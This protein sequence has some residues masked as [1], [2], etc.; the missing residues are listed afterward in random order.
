MTVNSKHSALG[1]ALVVGMIL[2]MAAPRA[3]A[4][5]SDVTLRGTWAF[6]TTGTIILPNVGPAPV[7]AV[8]RINFDG[9]GSVAGNQTRSVGGQVAEETFSGT[10]K[11]AADCTAD[12]TAQVFL[13]G[14]LV[15]TSTVYLILDD[16]RREIRAIFTSSFLPDNTPLPSI[17]TA[18][19]KRLEVRGED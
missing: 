4:G 8:G 13:N 15:R 10:Y 1:M 9:K 2:S 12:F 3:R 17:L 7:G 16:A 19:A 18:E 11:V 14:V 6:T 5:C